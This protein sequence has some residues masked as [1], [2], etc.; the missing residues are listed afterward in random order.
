MEVLHRPDLRA[1][2]LSREKAVAWERGETVAKELLAPSACHARR[3]SRQTDPH[4]VRHHRCNPT[5]VECR[6]QVRD[7]CRDRASSA[8]RLDRWIHFPKS[9][10]HHPDHQH[11]GIVDWECS[12]RR[13]R[14]GQ[15]SRQRRRTAE[16]GVQKG[17]DSWVSK[18]VSPIPH[19]RSRDCLSIE[20][21][22]KT[23]NSCWIDN[24]RPDL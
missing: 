18:T 13:T 20:F 9:P 23:V 22:P 12:W 8:S 5:H 2:R 15:R 14:F 21:P 7:N 17:S 1:P 4:L 19:Q 10:R 16:T 6:K 24:R 3:R 11:R